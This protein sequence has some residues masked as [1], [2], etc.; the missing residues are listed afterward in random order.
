[1]ERLGQN[2][3]MNPW[4]PEGCTRIISESVHRTVRMVPYKYV[5]EGGSA[6]NTC[7]GRTNN[8][9][10]CQTHRWVI[11]V[12]L[13]YST[14]LMTIPAFASNAQV[15]WECSNYSAEAQARC[16]NGF[17]ERQQER[18]NKLEGQLQ[19]Q[20]SVVGQLKGQVDRQAA[21]T[22]GLQ[23]QLS[24]RQATAVI[25]TPY[26][27]SYIYPPVGLGIYLGRPWNYSLPYYGYSRSFWG[28]RHYH[29]HRGHR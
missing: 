2:Q 22:V 25:P 5:H 21:A 27:Y 28:L 4:L 20:Q 16:F 14:V 29:R 8:F 6:M 1:M 3:T 24:Q 11:P 17:I 19:A 10:C 18:I 26:T 9:Q 23:Q 12:L 7:M 13:M 15:P